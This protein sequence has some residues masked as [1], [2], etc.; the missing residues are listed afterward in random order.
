MSRI[1]DLNIGEEEGRPSATVDF[2]NTVQLLG[3]QL[4]L[5]KYFQ[6]IQPQPAQL[7]ANIVMKI[8]I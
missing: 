5:S 4:L 8:M 7:I 6:S 3:I 1:L 2:V